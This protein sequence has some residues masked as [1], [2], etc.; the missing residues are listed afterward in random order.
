VA[1]FPQSDVPFIY[2]ATDDN[3][4]FKADISASASVETEITSLFIKDG[5]SEIT[6][7]EYLLP[8][9]N[10]ASVYRIDEIEKGLAVAT[11][12]AAK[13]KDECGKLEV[14]TLKSGSNSGELELAKYPTPGAVA[15][16]PSLAAKQIPMSFTGLGK[17]VGLDYKKK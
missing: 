11:N 10:G 13:A 15:E 7:F 8:N 14:F 1:A 9:T 5:Y 4:V 6:A 3:R 16:K 12:N 2:Y 17:I